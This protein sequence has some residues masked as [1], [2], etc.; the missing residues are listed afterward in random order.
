MASITGKV[1]AAAVV[2]HTCQTTKPFNSSNSSLCAMLYGPFLHIFVTFRMIHH[3]LFCCFYLSFRF[4]TLLSFFT[5]FPLFPFPSPVPSF[6]YSYYY[7][8]ASLPLYLTSPTISPTLSSPW[9]YTP[10]FF[11]IT[12]S[13][14]LIPCG[15]LPPSSS[16]SSWA[17]LPLTTWWILVTRVIHRYWLRLPV[18]FPILPWCRE[19]LPLCPPKYDYGRFL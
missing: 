16:S 4:F 17:M 18:S 7:H 12:L 6:H 10:S 1:N 2:Y 8:I 11:R 3:S 13:F 14:T 5:S 9:F 15:P 19:A